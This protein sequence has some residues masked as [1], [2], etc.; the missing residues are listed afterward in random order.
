[1]SEAYG[2]KLLKKKKT[3]KKT[4]TRVED[5]DVDD[6]DVDDDDRL[7]D[8]LDCCRTGTVQ[9]LR[10]LLPSMTIDEINVLDTDLQGENRNSEVNFLLFSIV[11][12]TQSVVY[13]VFT[14]IYSSRFGADPT[15]VP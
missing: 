9:Q 2:T 15:R 10:A 11:Q 8:F 7:F 3:T 4:R 12:P 5:D 13:Y 6:D 14:Y 1:M